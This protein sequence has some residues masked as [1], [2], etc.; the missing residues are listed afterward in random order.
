MGRRRFSLS[1]DFFHFELLA[2]ILLAG[3]IIVSL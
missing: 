1:K 2:V 3:D